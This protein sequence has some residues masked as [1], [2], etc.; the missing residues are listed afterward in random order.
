MTPG[1]RDVVQSVNAARSDILGI[2]TGAIVVLSDALRL[3]AMLSLTRGEQRIEGE[4]EEPSDRIPPL[5]GSIELSY[6]GGRDW[7]ASAWLRFADRQSRLSERDVRD[8]RIDPNGTPGWGMLGGKLTWLPDSRWSLSLA[9]D[10]VLDKRYRVHGS[11]L[12]DP[13][14]NLIFRVRRQF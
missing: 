4:T 1:G 14:R 8:P 13:G 7:Q 9:V 3:R 10:N 11:G 6:D 2:E 12:D 5:G